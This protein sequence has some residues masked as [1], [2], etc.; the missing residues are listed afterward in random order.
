MK[1]LLFTLLFL[2]API[3]E[4][5]ISDPAAYSLQATKAFAERPEH[6]L[7]S[8]IQ[9][10][11]SGEAYLRV[12]CEAELRVAYEPSDFYDEKFHCVFHFKALS[13]G[14]YELQSSF[15]PVQ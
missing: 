14:G 8:P 6:E 3:A 5:A 9:C 4:A 13:Q 1:T 7:L 2:T 15:C 10:S 12:R 11:Q